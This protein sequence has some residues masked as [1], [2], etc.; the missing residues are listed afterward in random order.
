MEHFVGAVLLLACPFT[1]GLQ[2][3]CKYSPRWCYLNAR[4]QRV[5]ACIY[6]IKQLAALMAPSGHI[7][8]CVCSLVN[9]GEHIDCGQTWAWPSM[10][11]K[12]R[13]LCSDLGSNAWGPHKLT[14]QTAPHRETTVMTNTETDRLTDRPRYIGSNRPHLRPHI[15]MWPNHCVCYL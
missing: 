11:Q 13:F 1:L 14:Y 8:T 3:R 15:V 7:A 10:P 4:M 9:K 5:L 2:R 6:A 12:C